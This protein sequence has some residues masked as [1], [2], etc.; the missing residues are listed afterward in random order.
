MATAMEAEAWAYLAVRS[1]KKL[2]LTFPMTTACHKPVSG[3]SLLPDTT[4]MPEILEMLKTK[5]DK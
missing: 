2:P 1:V 3:G 5:E 4:E